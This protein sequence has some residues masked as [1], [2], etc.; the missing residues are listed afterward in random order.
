M[1]PENIGQ[2]IRQARKA[3]GITQDRLASLM[4][5][6]RQTVSSWEN[7]RTQPDYETLQKLA[8]LLDINLAQVFGAAETEED[9]ASDT[10]SAQEDPDSSDSA[11]AL[12]STDSNSVSVTP[13]LTGVCSNE[14]AEQS[15]AIRVVVQPAKPRRRLYAVIAAAC[16]A[17]LLLFAGIHGRFA[18][19]DAHYTPEQ[20]M[21]VQT[22]VAGQAHVTLYTKESSLRVSRPSGDPYPSWYYTLSLREDNGVGFQIER[23]RIVHFLEDGGT[24]IRDRSASEIAEHKQTSHLNGYALMMIPMGYSPSDKNPA[25]LLGVG[26]LLEG[27]DDNGNRL[28]FTHYIE[29]PQI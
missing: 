8:S 11:P 4:Y 19:R 16:A 14:N 21:Q 15:A 26:F 7:A 13:P 1:M 10:D 3:K 18:A 25:H 24:A 22:P 5:V 29:L 27:H 2:H 17:A 28:R 9:G 12:S 6:S 23:L 20:F